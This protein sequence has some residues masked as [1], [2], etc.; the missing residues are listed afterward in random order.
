MAPPT[1]GGSVVVQ[2]LAEVDGRGW[3]YDK[4]VLACSFAA[5]VLGIVKVTRW[6]PLDHERPEQNSAVHELWG[7]V[8]AV[9]HP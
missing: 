1:A 8:R 5:A 7:R 2:A 3:K 6:G 4:E 9:R